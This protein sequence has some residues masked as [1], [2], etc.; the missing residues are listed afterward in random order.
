M[1]Q[2]INQTNLLDET[3][4]SNGRTSI[5]KEAKQL[6]FDTRYSSNFFKCQIMYIAMMN[7][8]YL[9]LFNFS[10]IQGDLFVTGILFGLSEFLGILLSEPLMRKFPD[11]LALIGSVIMIIISSVLVKTPGVGQSIVYCLFLS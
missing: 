7:I 8:Y 4:N 11:W 5:F 2:T 10:S 1:N 9:A 3:D 6:F